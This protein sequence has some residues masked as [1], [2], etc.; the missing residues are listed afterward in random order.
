L[1]YKSKTFQHRKK[2]WTP[3]PVASQNIFLIFL[4]SR[5]ALCY[6]FKKKISK[7]FEFCILIHQILQFQLY[8]SKIMLYIVQS[9]YSNSYWSQSKVNACPT[10]DV[11]IL[12]PKSTWH[13]A[14]EETLAWIFMSSLSINKNQNVWSYLA[15]ASQDLAWCTNQLL[16]LWFVFALPAQMASPI[17]CWIKRSWPAGWGRWFCL[18]NLLSWD[19]TWNTV[20]GSGSPNTI[21]TSSSWS[22]SRQVPRR[23]SEGCNTCPMKK[24]LR[25]LGLLSLEKVMGGRYGGLPVP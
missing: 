17:I 10:C 8:M 5:L 1:P 13:L 4:I 21:K 18:S 19:S 24:R 11:N 16:V 15:L 22:L 20:S 2:H 12:L 9:D 25:E 6:S 14:I 3:A 23:W 7:I